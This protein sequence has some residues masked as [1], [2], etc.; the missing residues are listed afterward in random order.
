MD[1]QNN[2]YSLLSASPISWENFFEVLAQLTSFALTDRETEAIIAS[3]HAFHARLKRLSNRN[4]RRLAE[5]ASTSE[6]RRPHCRHDGKT[7]VQNALRGYIKAFV[8]GY[9]VKF[10]VESVPALLTGRLFKR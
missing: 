5:E 10:L 7:C 4:L 9:G 1:D 6:Y 8:V 3:F 2:Y